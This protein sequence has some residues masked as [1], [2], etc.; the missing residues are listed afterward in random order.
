[1]LTR[2]ECTGGNSYALFHRSESTALP[3]EI[4]S[5]PHT[6]N[7]TPGNELDN[8]LHLLH[9]VKRPVKESQKMEAS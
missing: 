7:S 4:S 9:H 8:E 6:V 5:R 1:M 3:E 2:T